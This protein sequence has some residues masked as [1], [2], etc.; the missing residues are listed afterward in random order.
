MF[1]QFPDPANPFRRG[2]VALPVSVEPGGVGVD[3]ATSP[4]RVLPFWSRGP[5]ASRAPRGE[6]HPDQKDSSERAGLTQQTIFFWDLQTRIC[7]CTCT[8]MHIYIIVCIH[9]C[10]SLSLSLYIYIYKY[11]YNFNQASQVK[12]CGDFPS[13]MRKPIP[14][15]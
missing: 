10:V 11:A 12:K 14:L 7:T 2:P 15:K 9:M 8:H 6:I 5:P 3:F 13:E 4:L 1:N